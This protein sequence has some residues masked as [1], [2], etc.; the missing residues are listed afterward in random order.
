MTGNA[1]ILDGKKASQ[2]LLADVALEI[3]SLEGTEKPK[4]VAVLV[5]E[6]PA[7]EIYV[8]RKMRV[9]KQVGVNS[10]LN[11]Y[12]AA[13][14]EQELVS[15]LQALNADPS[16]HAILV[17]LPLPRHID[18]DRVLQTVL[19]EKDVDGFH[20]LN[21]GKLLLGVHPYALPCTPAGII[22]LLDAYDIPLEGMRAAVV[23]RS[24][25]VGKPITLLLTQR[26][27]TVTLCH[28]KTRNL[29]GVLQ[30]SDLVVAAIGKAGLVT[31]EMIKPGAVVVDVGINRLESGKVVGDVDFE[32]VSRKVG[33]ITPVPGGV[34][35]M[36][37]GMLMV[38]TMRLYRL[39][40]GEQPLRLLPH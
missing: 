5:G 25:I 19:P 18:T 32:P 26:N 38:N 36:T 39:Q 24:N 37:I 31:A 2:A 17:Q 20:P 4:L 22:Q 11:R 3:K 1:R 8:A 27:A 40:K 23:G 15:H 30:E 34:G 21:L 12:S 9:A 14:E 13:I 16:V 6:S 33:Y 10:E 28:S 29:A 35:P 7:S